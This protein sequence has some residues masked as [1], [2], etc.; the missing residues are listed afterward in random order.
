MNW[1]GEDSVSFA[2]KSVIEPFDCPMADEYMNIGLSKLT[3]N[4]QKLKKINPSKKAVFDAAICALR[5]EV[6]SRPDMYWPFIEGDDFVDDNESDE[7]QNAG[8]DDEGGNDGANGQGPKESGNDSANI[9]GNSGV[10][11]GVG[12]TNSGS[13]TTKNTKRAWGGSGQGRSNTRQ[14]AADACGD[15]CDAAGVRSLLRAAS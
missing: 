13:G 2:K 10:R 12:G 4:K 9:E 14:T 3:D 15:G 8:D 11:G 6:K 5:D 1:L 7:D